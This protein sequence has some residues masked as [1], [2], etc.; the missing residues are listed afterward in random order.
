M[1]YLRMYLERYKSCYDVKRWQYAL[2][3]LQAGSRV[4][5]RRKK[6]G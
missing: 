2:N 4:F 5:D 1:I 3:D 6:P